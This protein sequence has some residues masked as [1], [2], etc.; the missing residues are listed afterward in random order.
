MTIAEFQRLIA[1]IYLTKDSRRGVD[2][3]FRWLV[4]ETGELARALRG[5][6]RSN[7]AEEFADVFAWL[8]SLATQQGI[9]LEQA[10]Q[11]YEGGCPK[12]RAI[13]CTCPDEYIG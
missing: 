5:R 8:V 13:P 6:D 10:C 9:D 11:K 4:E 1:D 12:C 3:T 7:L 2:G